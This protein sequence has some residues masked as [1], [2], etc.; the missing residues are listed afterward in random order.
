MLGDLVRLARSDRRMT[1]QEVAER[2][3]ISRTTLLNIEKGLP[4][5]EIGLVF[6]VATIVGVSLFSEEG[7]VRRAHGDRLREKLSL[8]PASVR[9]QAREFDDDF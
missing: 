9:W 1:A 4:T 6:E 7:E 2:A 5:T 8:I 3:G